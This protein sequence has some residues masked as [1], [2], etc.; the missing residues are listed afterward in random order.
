MRP[1]RITSRR[2]LFPENDVTTIE[3]VAQVV[4]RAVSDSAFRQRLTSAPADTLR[5]EQIDVPPETQ[6]RILENTETLRHFILRPRPAELSDADLA[7]IPAGGGESDPLAAHARL[8]ADT[9]RDAGLRTRLIADP[10]SVM[11]ERGIAVPAGVSIRVVDASD[12]ALYLV[13]PP[14]SAS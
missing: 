14:A 2:T 1:A 8:V 4:D 9:W 7:G 10:T 11:A 13:I 5:G 3:Q 6:I 12:G